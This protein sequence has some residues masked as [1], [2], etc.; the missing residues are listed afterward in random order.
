[1]HVWGALGFWQARWKQKR[2]SFLSLPLPLPLPPLPF[3]VT[4]RGASLR[5]LAAALGCAFWYSSGSYE[6]AAAAA[7]AALEAEAGLGGSASGCVRRAGGASVAAA[8][9]VGGAGGEVAGSGCCTAAGDAA[10]LVVEC[11]AEPLA[12]AAA[13]RLRRHV[14]LCVGQ[15]LSWQLR[16][17]YLLLHRVQRLRALAAPQKRQVVGV[18]TKS[19]IATVRAKGVQRLSLPSAGTCCL[20]RGG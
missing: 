15:S 16:P 6:A 17:Q 4:G 18:V 12:E 14:S 1:M 9:L 10:V 3:L 19:A 5:A 20:V 2:T 13:G 7:A 11:A 8:V